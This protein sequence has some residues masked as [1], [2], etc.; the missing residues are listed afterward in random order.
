MY[1]K[2]VKEP[3]PDNQNAYANWGFC[4]FR[5]KEYE[6]CIR[7]C[8]LALKLD[9]VYKKVYYRLVQAHLSLDDSYGAMIYAAKFCDLFPDDHDTK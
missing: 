7:L 4:A 6:E 3:H 5:L 2:Y 8:H 9:P 1:R